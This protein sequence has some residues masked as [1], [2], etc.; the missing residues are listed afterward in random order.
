MSMV[1]T[2]RVKEKLKTGQGRE[3]CAF[4]IRFLNGA[5]SLND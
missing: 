4:V 5:V 2:N 3:C 1:L